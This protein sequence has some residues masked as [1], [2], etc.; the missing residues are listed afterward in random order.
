MA[1]R[2]VYDLISGPV[3]PPTGS[4]QQE[5]R[6]RAT[7]RMDRLRAFLE[8]LGNPQ[9]QYR[10]IHIGGTSGKGSTTA[11]IASILS[12]AGYRTGS[13]VSPYL[14]VATEKLEINGQIASA[15]EYFGLVNFMRERV[16]QWVALGNQ[17][18]TYGEFWVAMTFV[19]FARQAVDFAVIEVG[20]GGRFDLTNVITPEVAAITSIGLDH[21]VTLG[22]TLPEIAWHKAG[23]LK[24][25]ATAIT[26]VTEP[27]PLEAIENEARS[28]GIKLQKIMP[29]RSYSAVNT[30][31]FGTSFVDGATGTRFEMQLAGDF[32][33]A[34]G[35]LAVAVV[36]AI[37]GVSVS[38]ETIAAGLRKTRF[39][40]RMEIVQDSPHVLLDGAHN[41]QKVA[42]LANNLESLFAG[43][44]ITMI[45]GALESKQHH[46][47]LATLAP[48]V[49]RLVA[50]SPQVYAKPATP[51][52]EIVASAAGV[53]GEVDAVPDPLE[54]L[55]H[56]LRTTPDSGVIVVTGSLY[57]VGNIR[58]Y[59][60]S[61]AS[62]LEQG[63]IWPS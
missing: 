52:E 61:T 17:Q 55:E 43:R 44:S 10:T 51:V 3:T 27:A 30:G 35:A 20:A 12:E 7:E 32:Q 26:T 13:H 59:W 25:S 36:R 33:A 29:G 18:T 2:Y 46:E 50:T 53:I 37:P 4:S 14:Q 40:G 42:G 34:N 19:Y 31:P 45:F 21:T 24:A 63:S 56:A 23:I 57:L 5:I 22:A 8:F 9:D 1:E 47:M 6:Q 62:I 15:Q 54:A 11:L 38:D 60:Y 48:Y 58:E 49:S 41:P 16:D 39:P 28:L